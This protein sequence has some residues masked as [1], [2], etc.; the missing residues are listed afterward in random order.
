HD[1][2]HMITYIAHESMSAK[3]IVAAFSLNGDIDVGSDPPLA[4]KC[5]LLCDP[6]A[7]P[8]IEFDLTRFPIVDPAYAQDWSL[9]WGTL[10]AGRAAPDANPLRLTKLDAAFVGKDAARTWSTEGL[11]SGVPIAC[12]LEFTP[13]REL[14]LATRRTDRYLGNTVTVPVSVTIRDVQA[15]W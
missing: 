5:R 9:M 14:A 15:E 7:D 11:I 13:A 10:D 4:M 12:R 3:G 1:P 6:R 2:D 8:V